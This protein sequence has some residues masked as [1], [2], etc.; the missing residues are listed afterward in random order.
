MRKSSYF[1]KILICSLLIVFTAVS[2][3]GDELIWTPVNPS[4]GGNYMNASW[5]MQQAEAQNKL[6]AKTESYSRY[7]RDPLKNFKED[8]NRRILSRF[9]SRLMESAFGEAELGPGHY[10]IGDYII[11]IGSTGSGITIDITDPTT[12]TTTSMEVPY[13]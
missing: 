11:D 3:I 5:M 13:Y 10:E 4:F 1:L 12:G 9:S 8:L 2:L 6:K 7:D